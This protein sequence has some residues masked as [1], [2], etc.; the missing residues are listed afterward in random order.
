MLI[1]I[2]IHLCQFNV[3]TEQLISELDSFAV[4]VTSV[5]GFNYVEIN[6]DTFF[7]L[8]HS[9]QIFEN[10][11]KFRYLRNKVLRSELIYL[12]NLYHY[13]VNLNFPFSL[14]AFRYFYVKSGQWNH[15]ELFD[16]LKILK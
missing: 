8:L 13:H 14:K 5:L 15:F 4:L 9:R 12:S 1:M 3:I 6:F 16:G 11:I 10:L 7:L 2:E